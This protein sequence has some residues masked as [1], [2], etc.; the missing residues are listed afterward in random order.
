MA[1][2]IRSQSS[3]AT[4]RPVVAWA[5]AASLLLVGSGVVRAVQSS[6]HAEDTGYLVECP[7]PLKTIPV[8]IGDWKMQGT[9]TVLDDL[10]TR[11]T[12]S[13]DHIIRTYVDEMTGVTLSVL[14]LFGP[15]E[16]V[17]P[18]TPQVCYPSSGFQAIGN[19]V[20]RDIKIDDTETARFRSSVFVKSGGRSL[21]RNTVYHSFLLTGPW[22]PNIGNEKF[23]R[24]NPGIFKVQI[25]R[26]VVD[27]EKLDGDEPIEEFVQKL[28]PVL[29]TMIK[30]NSSPQLTATPRTPAR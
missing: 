9:E 2:S 10:T 15:A 5:L 25:Q 1:A 6:R 11:I 7:F 29:D 3:T 30:K 20:D 28:L 13:T 26:R 4:N 21:I 8:T 24:K 19:P 22:T 12:G 23:P 27:G 18:H 16:P 17:L 14:V